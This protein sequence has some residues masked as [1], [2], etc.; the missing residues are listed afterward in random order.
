[1]SQAYLDLALEQRD[2]EHVFLANFVM[3]FDLSDR[4]SATASF[5]TLLQSSRTPLKRR[6]TDSGSLT[7]IGNTLLNKKLEDLANEIASLLVK[8]NEY[9]TRFIEQSFASKTMK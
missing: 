5:K 3:H 1:M 4:D 7:T 8:V 2:K 6:Q 9:S